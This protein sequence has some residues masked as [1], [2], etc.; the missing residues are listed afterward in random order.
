MK[1]ENNYY[2]HYKDTLSLQQTYLAERNKLT[3]TLLILL[4]LLAMFMYEPTMIVEKLNIYLDSRVK[5][6]AFGMKYLNTGLIFLLLWVL[7]RYYQTVV[8]IDRTY[9]YIHQCEEKL[10]GDNEDGY[11]VNREGV[12]YYK[13][14]KGEKNNKNP[15][16]GDADETRTWLENVLYYCYGCLLPIAI[17]LLAAFKIAKE[18]SWATRFRFVDIAGLGFIILMSLLYMSNVWLREEY[19]DRNKE[20][21]CGMKWYNRLLRYLR[22]IEFIEYIKKKL[23]TKAQ[24]RKRIGYKSEE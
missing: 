3:V 10:S 14:R 23:N 8:K 2:D 22:I 19:F 11:R 16:D 12:Y 5:G 4:L 24:P 6:L 1:S 7:T 17:I 20:E 9:K 15:K 13:Y 21:Y 18:S